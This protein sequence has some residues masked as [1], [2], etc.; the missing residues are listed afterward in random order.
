MH[1][2]RPIKV[3]GVSRVTCHQ[4]QVKGQRAWE[5]TLCVVTGAATGCRVHADPINF[6]MQY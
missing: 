1:C 4:L 5:A 6:V 2:P 3:Y